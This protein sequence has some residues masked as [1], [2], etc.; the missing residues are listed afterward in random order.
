MGILGNDDDVEGNRAMAKQFRPVEVEWNDAN[1]SYGWNNSER[2][3]EVA[4]ERPL[5]CKSI[6]YVLHE[7]KGNRLCIVQSTGQNSDSMTG[8]VS[9]V[10]T[11]PWK[12]ILQ[13]TELT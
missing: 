6:G 7:E 9:E 12:C 1:V 5:Y 10:L 3:E 13:I 4:I 8:A 2:A 11:I